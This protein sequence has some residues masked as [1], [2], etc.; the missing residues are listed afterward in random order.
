MGE[1]PCPSRFSGTYLRDEDAHDDAELVEGPQR[2]PQRGGRHFTHVHGD[3]TGGEAGVEANDETAE[4]E[5]LEGE[6]HL[7]EAHEDGRHEGENVGHQH[8]V[9]PGEGR[10]EGK[11][12]HGG[13]RG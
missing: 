3:K 4:D 13:Q 9:A 8:G 5:H 10:E 2:T 11:E 12:D 7:G 6:S 1:A